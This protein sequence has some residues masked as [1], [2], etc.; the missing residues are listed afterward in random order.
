MTVLRSKS[1]KSQTRTQENPL[2]QPC[3]WT[4][5]GPPGLAA[6]GAFAVLR[7]HLHA[8]SFKFAPDLH[9][10]EPLLDKSVPS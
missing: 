3:R 8:V 9:P 1:G 10:G 2:L 7:Q 4:A 5:S 6:G